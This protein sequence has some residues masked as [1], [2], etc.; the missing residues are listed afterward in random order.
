M[1]KK[2]NKATKRANAKYNSEDMQE[3][4]QKMI[5][6]D[7]NIDIIV[8]KYEEI[9]GFIEKVSKILDRFC[10]GPFFKKFDEY[11]EHKVRFEQF[12][13]GCQNL[14][15]LF[16]FTNDELDELDETNITD[17]SKDTN[18]QKFK[19]VYKSIKEFP[20]IRRMQLVP[21]DFMPF[22]QYWEG[23]DLESDWILDIPG[24]N[25]CPFEFTD[26]DLKL[27][28]ID[29]DISEKEKKYLYI[30]LV[31][32]VKQCLRLYKT[33]SSPDID[34]TEFSDILLESIDKIRQIPELR[35]CGK[36][37][38]KIAESA[39][40]L[41]SNFDSYYKDM[42][43]SKNPNVIMENFI[44]DV[45]TSNSMDKGLM[46]QFKKI[47]AFYKRRKAGQ[48]K[49]PRLD[50]MFESMQANLSIFDDKDDPDSKEISATN[51][52]DNGLT[53]KKSGDA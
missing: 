39:E 11:E 33:I 24:P 7:G 21:K 50:G 37:F 40:M 18:E 17:D 44:I 22:K 35:G 26:I 20:H 52:D 5:S 6:G 46:M 41:N 32:F 31:C 45:S 34:I 51:D 29:D 47:L 1:S 2:M 53:D 19:A 4:F 38:S 27:I 42:I 3:M 8:G 25:F 16:T 9:K 10:D 36:A 43:D 12:N 48:K 23:K 13:E 15:E 14:L 28:W 49:D 30:T